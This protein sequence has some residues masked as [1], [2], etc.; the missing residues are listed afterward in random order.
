MKSRC[1]FRWASLEDMY[2]NANIIG[3]LEAAFEPQL[4][5]GGEEVAMPGIGRAEMILDSISLFPPPPRSICVLE[6]KGLRGNVNTRRRDL[7]DE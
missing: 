7:K 2:L 5:I 3:L 4:V 6:R 1:M